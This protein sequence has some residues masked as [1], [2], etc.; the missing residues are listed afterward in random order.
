MN[1]SDRS[2]QNGFSKDDISSF[3]VIIPSLRE[4]QEIV[5]KLSKVRNNIL[6]LNLVQL[7]TK[8]ELSLLRKSLLSN[9]L[10][11]EEAVA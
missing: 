5:A 8:A 3:P 7:K 10:T 9:A 1:V 4:Q 2:A 6:E 11:Q